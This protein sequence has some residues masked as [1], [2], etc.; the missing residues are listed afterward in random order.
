MLN[1]YSFSK[2]QINRLFPFY[3]LI[4]K[5]MEISS[6]GKS[7]HKICDFQKPRNI[8]QF[9][10]ISSPKNQINVFD[11]LIA[12]QNQF[13]VLQLF[14][15]K[16]LILRGQF[17]YLENSDEILF[18][19]SPSSSSLEQVKENKLFIG[20]Y[21]KNNRLVNAVNTGQI[22]GIRKQLDGPIAAI[23]T[24]SKCQKNELQIGNRSDYDS[25][26][27]SKQSIDPHIRIN[28]NG[29][30]LYHNPAASHIDFLNYEDKTYPIHLFFKL[31]VRKIAEKKESWSFEASSN[32]VQYSFD[33][34]DVPLEGVINV[35]ARDITNS[36][37]QQLELEKL[38]FIV[39][40]TL[41]MVVI[42]DSSGKIDWVNRAFEQISGYKFSEVKG[43]KPGSFL[44]GEDTSLETVAYMRQQIKDAKPF[45]C[46]VYNYNKSGEGY[47]IRIKGQSI[48]DKNGKAINHFA[49]Q[50]DITRYKS[51]Q[52]DIQKSEK[53]YRDVVDNSLTMIITHNLDGKILTSNPVAEKIYGYSQ[54][55]QINHNISEFIPEDKKLHFK[56]HYLKNIIKN[57]ISTG[58]LKVKTKKG[59]IVY[60]LYNN[61]LFEEAGKEPF[62]MSS[63][64]DITK[65][66][67]LE[68]KLKRAKK[69]TEVLAQSK[70]NFLA[71]MSHEIRTPMNAIIGMSRQLQ[72][73]S[74]NDDQRSYL[75]IIETASENLLFI[76]NDI[77]DLSKLEVNKMFLEKI[78]FKL[79]VV[80]DGALKVMAYKAQ[81]KGIQLTKSY[82]DAKL[83]PVLIGDPHRI[84]Q[85]LLNVLS[86]AIKFT[87]VGGVDICCTVLKDNG[88]SQ[89]LE[90]KITDTGIGMAPKFLK[91]IFKKFTQEYE[92]NAENFGGTGLGMAITKSLVGKME[93]KIS[94]ESKINVGTTIRITFTLDKADELD[95]KTKNS[96]VVTSANLKGKK[97]LVVDDNRM[98]RMVA[99]VILKD[100]DVIISEA[101]NGEEAVN[102]LKN[103][104]CDLVLMD[105]QMPVLNGYQASKVIRQELKLDIPIIALT[106]NA[107]KGEK[108]K[109]LEFG[110]NDYVSKPFDEE[111]FL[112]V[113]GTCVGNP[114]VSLS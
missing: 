103:N 73:S 76:I 8:S 57:K 9:F 62:V 95:L 68:K 25:F 47:W 110:M 93:G 26:L 29:D 30:L 41:N 38:S 75:D 60:T 94:V 67:L 10:S 31:I 108:E 44:Q 65:H 89:Y 97:I 54:S 74:L 96:V 42:T 81:E 33:C 36:K 77:L 14:I 20:D 51:I 64:V 27:F 39:Q 17:Q 88:T 99:K 98:N 80:I 79:E 106:A 61:F 49:I 86:N 12:I 35:Y 102:Y 28:Y 63:S 82:F 5:N 53:K 40:E 70:H 19:G 112:Q 114:V 48:F 3:I 45:A 55:E 105:I 90:I 78:A 18:V 22:R 11:D 59:K 109:C 84:N 34:V 58:I 15:D 1:S 83:S 46:E 21:A 4:N 69:V 50:E 100:Y 87:E 92:A 66:V 52:Q 2:A 32:K 13:V 6:L 101:I 113:I 111:S 37:K 24:M 23:A 7:L 104:P 107:M 85:I 56:E 43:K 72:K 71:N 16:K 91:T